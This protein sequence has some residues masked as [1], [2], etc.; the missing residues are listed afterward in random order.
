MFDRIIDCFKKM[1][2]KRREFDEDL[3]VE[4]KKKIKKMTRRER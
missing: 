4:R 2:S 1:I 3:V